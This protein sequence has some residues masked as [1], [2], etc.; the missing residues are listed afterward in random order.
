M[1]GQNQSWH[2]RMQHGVAFAGGMYLLR[3]GNQVLM[4]FLPSSIWRNTQ[5]G[6]TRKPLHE[7]CHCRSKTACVL[8]WE[9]RSK[10]I[11]QTSLP[12]RQQSVRAL[13]SWCKSGKWAKQFWAIALTAKNIFPFR[14]R[15]RHISKPAD[16][17]GRIPVS[18]RYGI[19]HQYKH[20]ATFKTR[21]K[22]GCHPAFK[23]QCRIP[24]TGE[25]NQSS[26]HFSFNS[27]IPG[28]F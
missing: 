4:V 21:E 1:F 27:C 11:R 2:T 18:G 26:L 25:R 13:W 19:F 9:G 3:Q 28:S 6:G 5:W 7:C 12:W 23:L 15:V 8:S 20:H 22:G 24:D 17:I 14:Y 16:T 10:G